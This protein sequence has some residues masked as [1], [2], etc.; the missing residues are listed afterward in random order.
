MNQSSYGRYRR[1]IEAR[2]GSL[3]AACG[4]QVGMSLDLQRAFEAEQGAEALVAQQDMRRDNLAEGLL[5][6][7][8][9]AARYDGDELHSGTVKAGLVALAEAA[10]AAATVIYPEL[11]PEGE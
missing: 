1:R 8:A 2:R 11:E 6:A 9:G 3:T 7:L 4:G 5:S 10:L